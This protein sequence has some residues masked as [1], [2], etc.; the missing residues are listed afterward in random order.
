MGSYVFISITALYFYT[1]LLLA[2]LSAKKSKLIRDFIHVLCV[3]ILWTGGS[4][5][6]RLQTWPSYE[7]WYHISLAGIGLVPCAFFC[8]IRDFCG[9]PVKNLHK[10]CW[11]LIGLVL[12]YNAFTGQIIAPPMIVENRENSSFVYHMT[13]HVLILY[14][15]CLAVI[16]H[17]AVIIWISRKTAGIKAKVEPL[18]FGIFLM[19]AGNLAIP[20]FKGFPVDILSGIF[21]AIIMFYTLYSRH[22]FRMTLLV[23][24]GNCY[25]IAM[26]VSAVAFYNVAQRL[27]EIIRSTIPMLAR[28]SVMIV[29]M[30][31]MMITFIIY[32]ITKGFFD[33]LFIKDEISQTERLA[34][35]TTMVSKSLRL[36]EILQE[37]VSVISDTLHTKRIYVCIEDSD[38]NYP[39]VYSNSPL[40]NRNFKL[41]ATAPLTEWMRS[42]NNCL[43]L[44]DFKRTVEYKSMW[45]SEKEQLAILKAECFLPL[46]DGDDLVGMVLLGRK[47]NKRKVK[48]EYTEQDIMFLNSIESVSSI[49]VKNSRLYEKAYEEARTDE[50]TGLLNRKY[51]YEILDECYEKCKT[52]SLA[53]VI[54]NVD[55]FKLYNQLYGN[56]EGDHAL[57]H[58]AHIIRG[59]VGDNGYCSRY[60]GKEFAVILPN[61]DIYS[62]QNL[63]ENISRQIQAINKANDEIY[64]KQLT[65]SCGI[66]AIPYAASSVNELISNA[67]RAVYNVKRSG[68][69]GIRVYSDGV[70]GVRDTSIPSEKKHKSMYSEYAPTIYALTAAIDAKDHYT[71]Q[72]SKNVA[73]YAEALADA[74]HISQE[75]KEIIKE[76]A[77]L[78]DIG[79][80]GI[81]ENILNK[82][83]K[84]TDEEY[85]SMKRHVEASVEIIRHLPSMDY[86]VPAVIGH[87]E[88]YDGRGYP[89]RIAGKDIPLSARILCVA[90]AFDAIV[91]KRSYKPG[92]SVEFAIQELEKGAGSQFDPELVPVFIDLI[93]SGKIN[94]VM[95]N[96]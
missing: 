76:A 90:D 5:F 53:L 85:E 82:D 10:L 2:F 30:I 24:R 35:Y 57:I 54:F 8:F 52:T 37:L 84:L 18:L 87:H 96:V 26:A 33:R 64:L 68:K 45:E 83:G 58:I 62:A 34:E 59:T 1:F 19:Y 36:N 94:P 74:L 15:L 3:L 25:I 73:Y 6:M 69:N 75:Y 40:D 43:L 51:F 12:I 42:H 86:V 71:F 65:V 38:G 28:F 56:K 48:K 79:K 92:M 88:R 70:I 47:E 89:R 41:S 80:I 16:I 32:G 67:D 63:A 27:E 22:L 9:Y 29:A 55:D 46:K 81:S 44:R 91:S 60:T 20:I 72:H 61:F 78:H 17:S 93:E 13:W 21:N 31:M 23:S 50:L 11:I 14:G 77:L 66:C 4:L 7:F 39:A 49:A 95:K